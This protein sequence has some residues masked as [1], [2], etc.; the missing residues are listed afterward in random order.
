MCLQ[1][2]LKGSGVGFRGSGADYCGVIESDL[3]SDEI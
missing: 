2:I 3:V 1:W